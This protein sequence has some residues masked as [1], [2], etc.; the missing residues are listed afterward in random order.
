V[1][2]VSDNYQRV[3]S[4]KGIQRR[5]ES[6]LCI[7]SALLNLPVINLFLWTTCKWQRIFVEI[8]EGWLTNTNITYWRLEL[9][10][11]D[12]LSICGKIIFLVINGHYVGRVTSCANSHHWQP[13]DIRAPLWD[14]GWCAPVSDS[15]P[16]SCSWRRSVKVVAQHLTSSEGCLFKTGLTNPQWRK[17]CRQLQVTDHC[18]RSYQ[19]D[20]SVTV[21]ILSSRTTFFSSLT[22][23]ITKTLLRSNS[24]RSCQ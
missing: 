20:F 19:V 14:G 21:E 2:F 12:W 18:V 1:N 7:I 6:V 11:K 23:L 15:V 9:E 10:D 17:Q 22:L 8:T 24:W 3:V 5:K 4:M 16:L 13:F